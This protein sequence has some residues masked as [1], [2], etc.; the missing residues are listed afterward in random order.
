MKRLNTESGVGGIFN[1]LKSLKLIE[2]RMWI[3]W[4]VKSKEKDD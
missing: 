1:T 4:A 2:S 3:W